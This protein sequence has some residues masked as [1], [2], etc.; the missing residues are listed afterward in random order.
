MI[1]HQ[2]VDLG[3]TEESIRSYIMS[4]H[5]DKSEAHIMSKVLGFDKHP[6][7]KNF[8]HESLK[9]KLGQPQCIP[10]SVIINKYE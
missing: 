8:L 4:N 9:D 1:L 5:V 6:A 2:S 7:L 10:K 3:D